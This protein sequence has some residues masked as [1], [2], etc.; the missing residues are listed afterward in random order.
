MPPP[1]SNLAI[2]PRLLQRLKGIELRSRFL[3]RGLYDNRHRTTDFG[4]SNEFIEHRD[5]QPGDDI[6]AIDW[7]VYGR[8]N[9]HYVKR[10]EME[11]NMRVHFFLDTS[12]SMRVPAEGGRPTKLELAAVIAG[13]VA[14]MVVRQ[15]DSA[16]L[17]CIGDRIEEHIPPRQGQRHLHLLFQHLA[18][19]PGQGGSN[20]GAVAAQAMREIGARGV[21]FVLSDAL[22]PPEPLFEMLKGLVA[23][24]QD[25]SLLQILDRDELTFP[26]DKMTEFRH[27]ETNE[28]IMGDPMPLRQRYLDR[29]QE[30]LD[31]IES[32]CRR[33]GVD[34]LR[35]HNG[36]D[37]VA[38][39][40]SHLLKRLV[41]GAA[42][43]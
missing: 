24:E 31:A 38:L 17:Y 30:H 39:L 5:Y 20:F 2:D 14:T 29:L 28:R 7:R 6:G 41:R 26:F 21:V 27:P 36:E 22:D 1:T 35:L 3:A 40:S 34:Y 18:D 12:D 33:S 25:V 23:R 43:C 8:T 13:A 32:F 4:A 11:S 42:Q 16:G 9:R 10:F 19:P 37:L 15:Q